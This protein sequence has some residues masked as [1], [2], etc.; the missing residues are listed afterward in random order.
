MFQYT[1][2]WALKDYILLTHD[3]LVPDISEIIQAFLQ[4]CLSTVP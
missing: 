4:G 3:A 2:F 1:A